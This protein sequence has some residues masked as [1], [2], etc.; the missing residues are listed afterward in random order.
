MRED[1]SQLKEEKRELFRATYAAVRGEKT[2][3]AA[4]V[5]ASDDIFGREGPL[6]VRLDTAHYNCFLP[7]FA[8]QNAPLDCVSPMGLHLKYVTIK[9]QDLFCADTGAGERGCCF[10]GIHADP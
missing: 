4:A 8:W 7:S 6:R 2:P 10:Q 3:D 9:M 5:A 1:L